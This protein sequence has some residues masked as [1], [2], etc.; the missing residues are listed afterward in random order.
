MVEIDSKDVVVVVV[1]VILLVAVIQSSLSCKQIW[2]MMQF[3]RIDR[4]ICVSSSSQDR[5]RGRS[6]GRGRQCVNVLVVV[7]VCNEVSNKN[8]LLNG[9]IMIKRPGGR[10][11]ERERGKKIQRDVSMKYAK[12]FFVFFFFF[13]GHVRSPPV[14]LYKKGRGKKQERNQ[15]QSPRHQLES[16][17][18]FRLCR[19][20]RSLTHDDALGKGRLCRNRA[21]T[22]TRFRV[23]KPLQKVTDAAVMS[24]FSLTLLPRST[25]SV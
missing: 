7:V 8:F 25:D 18:L 3:N 19:R 13:S 21:K 23:A 20:T 17:H 10:E 22:A 24:L 16:N 2:P 4:G 11:R 9:R 14:F 12:S 1:V 6:R 5:G 15:T